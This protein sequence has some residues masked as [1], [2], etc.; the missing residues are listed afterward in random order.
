MKAL[1][2][3]IGVKVDAANRVRA[4][5]IVEGIG[6]GIITHELNRS[7]FANG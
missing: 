4:D 2:E 6:N 7:I 5:P 3:L 1:I